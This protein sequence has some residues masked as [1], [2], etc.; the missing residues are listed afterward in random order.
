[1]N[2]PFSKRSKQK[3]KI[4]QSSDVMLC[5]DICEDTTGTIFWGNS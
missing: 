5:S 3:N 4:K 1:M 2:A